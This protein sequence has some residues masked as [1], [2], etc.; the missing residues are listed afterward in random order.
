MKSLSKNLVLTSLTLFALLSGVVQGNSQV[1]LLVDPTQNWIGYVNVFDLP[2][3]GGGYEFGSPWGIGALTAYYDV[4]SAPYNTV[5]LIANTNNYNPTDPYW[6]NPDGSGNKTVDA[7]YYVQNDTLAGQTLTFSGNCL[8]NSF[9][10][11]YTSTVFIKE[12]SQS[13][14]L[15]KSAVATAVSGQPFSISLATD[16]GTHI[17]YGFETIGP[18]AKPA[19]VYSLGDAVYQ[20]QYPAILLSPLSGQAAIVGQNVTFTETPTGG[21]PFTYQWTLNGV[22]LVNSGHISGAKTGV[23]TINNV[24]LADVGTYAVNV[25]N[26]EAASG[27]ASAQLVL[28]PLAQAQTNLVI[29]PGFENNMFVADPTTGWYNYGNASFANTSGYYFDSPSLVPDVTVVD[30]TNCLEIASGGQN[31]YT[32]VFQDRPALPGQI[33]SA[34]AWFLT[35]PTYTGDSIYG[36]TTCNLQVQFKDAGGNLICDY[37]S[38]PFDT[39]Y[40]PGTWINFPVTNKYAA[41]YVTLLSTAT[42]IVA[43]PGTASMRIQPGYHT[44]ND[45]ISGGDMYVDGVVVKLLAPAVTATVSGSN[46]NLSFATVYG[47][48]YNVYRKN[49]LTDATWTLL[50]AVTGD[51]T[52]KT[53]SDTTSLASRFYIVNT[54]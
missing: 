20:V 37:E 26:S 47:L 8:N 12:F 3:N 14:S 4:A 2:S 41:D 1:S 13:Y 34:S 36:N 16:A 42:N 46:I 15:L 31:S 52:V 53:V 10:S 28:I 35:P 40:P 50:T 32:G 21:A 19:T 44:P 39:S 30:G 9:M 18:D 45:L 29:D 49:N 22:N 6:V 51:G 25:T 17:Q 27:S 11:P 7:S 54:Q 5:T 23:L 24:S 48:T 43:P 33:Y 38:T